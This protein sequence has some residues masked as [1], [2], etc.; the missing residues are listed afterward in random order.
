MSCRRDYF[1]PP[2]LILG[3]YAPLL[4]LHCNAMAG[5]KPARVSRWQLAS[6]LRRL[7]VSALL[8]MLL[9]PS[10]GSLAAFIHSSHPGVS[11][12]LVVRSAK[13]N[14]PE[15]QGMQYVLE[16]D[17]ATQE[18]LKRWSGSTKGWLRIAGL[19]T[20]FISL[21]GILL[22]MSGGGSAPGWLKQIFY[23]EGT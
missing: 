13:K 3:A 15:E 9:T 2:Q 23:T 4:P 17:A 1:Q 8:A 20:Q 22:L 11:C 18:E 10:K 5:R 14:E 12:Q 16:D 7:A 19:A 21:A 6:V